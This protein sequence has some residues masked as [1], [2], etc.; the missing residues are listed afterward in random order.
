MLLLPFQPV[1]NVDID[2][3]NAA[4]H[5][6]EYGETDSD[7]GGCHSHNEEH[8]YLAGGIVQVCRE[9]YQQEV[10]GIEHEFNAHEDDDAIAAKENSNYSN[11]E[12][13]RG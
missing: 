6:D 13:D 7:F 2:C 9:G 4:I 12:E 5:D 1:K 11:P 10:H 3:A 8:E